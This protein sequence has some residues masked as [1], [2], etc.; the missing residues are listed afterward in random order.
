LLDAENIRDELQKRFPGMVQSFA[1][2]SEIWTE[3]PP[4]NYAVFSEGLRPHI[5]S[6]LSSSENSIEL[7]KIF[8][9]LEEVADGHSVALLD[10][11][12]VEIVA[13]LSQKSPESESAWKYMGPRL[14]ELVG[15]ARKGKMGMKLTKGLASL[16]RRPSRP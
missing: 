10:V 7:R 8:S 4:N 11:L 15:E 14:K 2:N 3:S 1:G 13:P 5:F 9:L 6:I 16:S 12:Q